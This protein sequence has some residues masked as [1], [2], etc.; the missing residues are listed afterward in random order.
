MAYVLRPWGGG[1]LGCTSDRLLGQ[2][3]KVLPAGMTS[4][5]HLRMCG[6]MLR[7]QRKTFGL[8]SR[9]DRP[10]FVPQA[11]CAGCFLCTPRL[12]F[13]EL[14]GERRPRRVCLPHFATMR[15][16]SGDKKRVPGQTSQVMILSA[17]L[18]PTLNEGHINTRTLKCVVPL[19]RSFYSD[20][21]QVHP[22]PY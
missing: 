4:R 2:T 22:I 16:H 14:Y 21:H 6:Q 15:K 3:L 17:R 11:H 8:S 1:L 10:V 19:D 12:K 20:S 18:S 9:S 13:T 5:T 7:F